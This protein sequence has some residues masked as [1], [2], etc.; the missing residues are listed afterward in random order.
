MFDYS[1]PR[2]I[3]SNIR[4]PA[5]KSGKVTLH[6][7]PDFLLVVD[8]NKVGAV[9]YDSLSIRWQDSNFIVDGT[10]P[11]DTQVLRHVWKHPNKSGGPDR[12]FANNY[13]IPVCLYESIYLTSPNGLNELL[14]V[15]RAGA[16]EPFA[17]AIA[18]LLRVTGSAAVSATAPRLA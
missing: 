4:P 8:A 6:F 15:S 3:K 10:V 16:T 2:A 17:K 18:H 5:I 11:A 13:Q 7:L 12:R 1:L 9:G 14:Q